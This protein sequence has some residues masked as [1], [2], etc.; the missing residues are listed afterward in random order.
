M[1]QKKWLEFYLEHFQTVEINN[2]FYQLPAENTFINWH[3]SVPDNFTFAVK[4][5]RFITHMKKL[6]DPK[7]SLGKFIDRVKLLKKK[8]GVILYQLP[9]R[10]RYNEERLSQFLKTLPK[11]I[12]AAF[13]FRDQSWWN[14]DACELLKKHNAAFCIFELDKVQSPELVTTSFVYLRMHGPQGAYEGSYSDKE[15]KKWAEKIGNWSRSGLDVYCYFDNDQAAF[16]AHNALT[17]KRMIE[18]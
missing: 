3:K 6:K 14:D 13:E 17:L 7:E 5:S 16:A 4:V 11:N 1:P 2:T 15:L 12:R 10:W 8:L 9:P 18:R